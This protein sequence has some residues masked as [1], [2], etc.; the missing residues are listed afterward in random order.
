MMTDVPDTR[1]QL[2]INAD[3][4]LVPIDDRS[5]RLCDRR[6][7][8]NDAPHVV[9]YIER[10]EDIYDVVWTRGVRRRSRFASL[11]ACVR[12]AEAQIAAE[13]LPGTRPAVISAFPPPRPA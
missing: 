8:V 5:W 6:W 2:P 4:E 9:A 1:D 13:V 3:L 11:D 10:V 7:R 12:A